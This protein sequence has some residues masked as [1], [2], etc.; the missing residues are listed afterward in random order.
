MQSRKA[1]IVL[2]LLVLSMVA[3][4]LATETS[5]FQT[6]YQAFCGHPDH[7]TDGWRGP[8]HADRKD[9]MSDARDHMSSNRGHRAGTITCE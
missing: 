5:A 6:T 3:L 1:R 8:C 7:G 4:T 2:C 9:A